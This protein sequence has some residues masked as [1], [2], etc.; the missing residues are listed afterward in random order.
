MD[1]IESIPIWFSNILFHNV[2]RDALE[3]LSCILRQPAAETSGK[4]ALDVQ[5]AVAL[6]ISRNAFLRRCCTIRIR[7][8]QH[9]AHINDPRFRDYA[10]I[11]TPLMVRLL[12]DGN[13]DTAYLQ[14]KERDQVTEIR[15]IIVY[16]K[17]TIKQKGSHY[18][19]SIKGNKGK[20]RRG[21]KQHKARSSGLL[22][23]LVRP[24]QNGLAAC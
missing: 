24:L 14:G 13:N 23:D 15:R 22:C 11:Q 16:N 19:G 2:L 7:F 10:A 3:H 1:E 8:L 4:T 17:D 20:F 18:Y 21:S 5:S 6:G 12:S 9:N